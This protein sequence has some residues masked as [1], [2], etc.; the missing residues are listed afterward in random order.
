GVAIPPATRLRIEPGAGASAMVGE[1]GIRVG[2]PGG[3]VA[4]LAADADRMAEAG[5]TVFAVDDEGE[6]LGLIGVSDRVK[7]E[8]AATVARLA[9]MGMDVA[10]VTGDR[11]ATTAA[12]AAAAGIDR[13]LAE[14]YPQ[15]KVDEVARLQREGHR[16]VFVGDG[17]NDA[18]A[19]AQADVGVALG[20]GTD[21]AIEAADVTLLGDRIEAVADAL[22]LA[23]RTYRV[24]A[25]NLFW[26]FAYNVV[27]IPLAVIGVLTPMLA[28]GAMAASSVSVVLNALRLRRFHRSSRTLVSA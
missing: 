14:V 2:R 28:A 3:S 13:V 27:M 22:E 1:R 24:I 5:L 4:G 26:A 20:S 15:G 9:G 23:R 12:I 8:S 21:V 18:P 7:P 17:I 11:R 6:I 19:L 25:E 16:V 10:M